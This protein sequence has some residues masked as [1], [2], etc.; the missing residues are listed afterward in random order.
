[1]SKNPTKI[2]EDALNEE[3]ETNEEW[4]D[5]VNSMHQNDWTDYDEQPWTWYMERD[6]RKHEGWSLVTISPIHKDVTVIYWLKSQKA[7][8]KHS[9]NEFLIQDPQIAM[10]AALQYA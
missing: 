4:W 1:M 9:K 7:K 2:I 10:M 3:F 5:Y 8:F 6:M